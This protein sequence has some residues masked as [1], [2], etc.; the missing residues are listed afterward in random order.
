MVDRFSAKGIDTAPREGRSSPRTFGKELGEGLMCAGVIRYAYGTQRK[1]YVAGP[2]KIFSI[3]ASKGIGKNYDG[4]KVTFIAKGGFMVFIDDSCGD[5]KHKSEK[6]HEAASTA[7]AY[8]DQF[9][10]DI[11]EA[12]KTDPKIA[13]FVEEHGKAVGIRQ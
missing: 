9:R 3:N 2:V 4:H 7:K 8:I 13:A 6:K 5:T 10:H 11:L 12:A 1:D